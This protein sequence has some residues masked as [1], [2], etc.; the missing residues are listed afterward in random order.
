MR[1]FKAIRFNGI[2]LNLRFDRGET[3]SLMESARE[4]KFNQI[5]AAVVG[6]NC[7]W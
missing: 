5:L 3:Q 4:K 2:S 7:L 1:L 6:E